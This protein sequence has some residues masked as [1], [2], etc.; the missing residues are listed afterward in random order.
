MSAFAMKML[1]FLILFSIRFSY[2]LKILQIVPGFTNS[3][4]LFNYR[5]SETLTSQ[6]H[7]VSMLSQ[8][9]MN[10][11][12]VGATRLP[13]NVTEYRVP[14]HFTDTLKNEGLKVDF[15]LIF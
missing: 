8:M 5:L 7:S 12:A 9:E 4:I 14:I 10:M 1:Y 3:H 2:G 15:I 6:G 13:N 11:V